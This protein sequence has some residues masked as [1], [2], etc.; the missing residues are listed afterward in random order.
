M[1]SKITKRR[2]VAADVPAEVEGKR[3]HALEEIGDPR[4]RQRLELLGICTGWRCLEVGAGRGSV[5][6][7]MAERVGPTGQVVA[8]DIDPRFLT[9]LDHPGLEI[10]EHDVLERDFETAHYDVVHCRALLMHL[11]SPDLAIRRMAAAVRPGGWLFMEE[12]DF[13]AWG[14]VEPAYPGAAAFE[15]ATRAVWDTLHRLEVMDV[16]FGRRLSTLVDQLGWNDAD[17]EARLRV[18]Y[19]GDTVGRF[20]AVTFS[21]MRASPL[22]DAAAVTREDLD[23][24]LR[25]LDDPGFAFLGPIPFSA[26]CKRP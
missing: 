17:H 18:S 13:G 2:Y 14:A 9:T 24:T 11:S 15:R 12:G 26:W 16:R 23:T 3:L 21:S 20:W 7:W 19:G 22:V 5:A 10:R 6:L 4:T 25:L 8:V 1:A